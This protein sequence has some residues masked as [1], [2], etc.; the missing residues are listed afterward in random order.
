MQCLK[1]SLTKKEPIIN[2]LL[3]DTDKNIKELV[4]FLKPKVLSQFIDEDKDWIIN[5]VDIDELVICYVKELE[6]TNL[7]SKAVNNNLN[8]SDNEIISNILI[9]C[10]EKNTISVD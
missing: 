8:S 1:N 3:T 6:K 5:N 2:L 7:I 4:K 10:I 9:R